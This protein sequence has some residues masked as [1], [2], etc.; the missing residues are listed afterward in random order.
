MDTLFWK[1]LSPKI[2][3]GKTVKQFYKQYL[4]RL[5]INAPGCKS[6][7]CDNIQQDIDQRKAHARTYGSG[8]W[9]SRSLYA[10]LTEADV[11]FLYSLKDLFYEY[12]D[13]KIRIEEPKFAIYATDETMIKSVATSID[14]E[15]RFR[16]S[17]I[18]GPAST[19]AADLLKQNLILVSKKPDYRYRIF[20]KEK[21]IPQESREQIINYLNSIDD[22]V[23]VPSHMQ[24]QMNRIGDW[25]WGCYFYT[26]DPHVAD[27]IRL[28][29]PEVI[30]E[31][32]EFVCVE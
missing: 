25:I 15:Q 8:S 1:T 6:I 12:P 10:Q 20:F 17:K 19:Q 3:I 26:N 13:V 4:Y 24:D 22:L 7:K 32:C 18:T 5:E 9:W 23:R 28:I 29:N 30:R 11:G 14:K 31:V 16:L 21:R 2:K 27:M